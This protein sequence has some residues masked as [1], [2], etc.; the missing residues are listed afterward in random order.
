MDQQ[1][2][3]SPT[4]V[5]QPP[6]SQRHPARAEAPR[7]P[8]QDSN[9]DALSTASGRTFDVPRSDESRGGQSGVDWPWMN[10]AA[11]YGLPSLPP[12]VQATAVAP[13]AS[14][15]RHQGQ[16]Q[17]ASALSSGV[18]LI[19]PEG[20]QGGRGD[21]FGG[22][23]PQGPWQPQPHVLLRRIEEP[24]LHAPSRQPALRHSV[25]QLPQQV[26]RHV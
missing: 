9:T 14:G 26:Q 2:W 18:L 12:T 23:G 25:P 11:R 5:S 24:P 8:Q 19:R 22:Q 3:P 17:L 7:F 1:Q 20:S 16:H 21:G 6:N 10:E 15:G 4:P 13:V